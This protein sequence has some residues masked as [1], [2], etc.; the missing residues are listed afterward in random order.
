MGLLRD[1]WLPR[2]PAL[3]PDAGVGGACPWVWLSCVSHGA[4]SCDSG[5][6]HPH[7]QESGSSQPQDGGPGVAPDASFRCLE[8]LSASLLAMPRAP[9]RH[10][11][12]HTTNQSHHGSKSPKVQVEEVGRDER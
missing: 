2:V 4:N 3:L 10:R 5:S 8:E 1:Q 11:K 9:G 7:S 12:E 6:Q